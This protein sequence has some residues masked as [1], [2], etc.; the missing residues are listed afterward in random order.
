MISLIWPFKYKPNH[1]KSGIFERCMESQFWLF[2]TWARPVAL[3]NQI[4]WCPV[5]C[6]TAKEETNFPLDLTS[7]LFM[8]L[9]HL[10]TNGRNFHQSRWLPQ[11]VTAKLTLCI[12]HLR[13]VKVFLGHFKGIIQIRHRII[14]EKGVVK[15]CHLRVLWISRWKLHLTQMAI[16]HQGLLSKW[17][18]TPLSSWRQTCCS[19]HV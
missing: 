8:G 2:K 11:Q 19:I 18:G 10:N 13:D 17:S 5:L 1:V 16:L 15:K 14:L 7:N 9:G 12:Q 3:S 6:D 4:T